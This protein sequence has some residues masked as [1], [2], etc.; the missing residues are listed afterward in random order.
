MPVHMLG[1]PSDMAGIMR[2]ARKHRL[3]VVEDCC[4]A[5]GAS[6]RGRKLGAI[7]HMGAFSLNIFQNDYGR[8]RRVVATDDMALYERAFGFHDQGH[9]PH[10][11]AS[12]S[13]TEALSALTSE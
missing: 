8:R 13:A 7:G 1:N 10:R 6:F 2:V 5:A 12:K 3:V 4:Q 9:K 11:S